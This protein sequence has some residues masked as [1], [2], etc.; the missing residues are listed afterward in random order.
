LIH[1]LAVGLEYKLDPIRRTLAHD[2]CVFS[3]FAEHLNATP[4]VTDG[5]HDSSVTLRAYLPLI[6]AP[7]R[8]EL[9][10]FE[11]VSS[12]LGIR[13][14][15]ARVALDFNLNMTSNNTS[16]RVAQTATA[17]VSGTEVEIL[18]HSLVSVPVSV[19]D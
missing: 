11:G 1:S 10:T 4:I 18:F 15:C 9:G 5:F 13:A 12:V 17:N 6:S 3:T 14:I 16:L 8:S 19:L 2:T 7:T